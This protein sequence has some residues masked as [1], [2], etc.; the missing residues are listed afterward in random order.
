[1]DEPKRTEK[2]KYKSITSRNESRIS[3]KL[4]R[5]L[6]KLLGKLKKPNYHKFEKWI[7]NF[8]E[9]PKKLEKISEK[10][11]KTQQSSKSLKMI[12]IKLQGTEKN[13]KDR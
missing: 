1:M 2:V 13:P 9:T 5:N 11:K 12:E 6:V 3:S 4:P 10:L 8:L 7:K